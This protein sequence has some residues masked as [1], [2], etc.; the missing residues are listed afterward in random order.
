M[1]RDLLGRGKVLLLFVL[2]GKESLSEGQV[3]GQN[4]GLQNPF[5]NIALHFPAKILTKT[6]AIQ[7]RRECKN[8]LCLS[9][10]SIND[11]E[12]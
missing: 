6:P 11:E 10:Y 12:K 9:L 8:G 3:L 2:S 5:R 7:N 1:K 4:L